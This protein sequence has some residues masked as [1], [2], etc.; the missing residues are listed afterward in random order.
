[1]TAPQ[2]PLSAVVHVHYGA[3]LRQEERVHT[4][5]V[6]VFGS[7]GVV[8]RHNRT[9]FDIPSIVIG[10]KGSVGA[11]HYAPNGG[12]VIDTAFYV[13]RLDPRSC[14]LRYLFHALSAAHLSR[15]AITTSIPGLSR[16]DIYRTRIPLPSLPEQQRIAD[17]LDKADAIRR[18]RKAAIALADDLLRSTFLD[19]FGDPVSNPK[20]WS[21]SSLES[22]ASVA[23]GVAKGKR[24]D[25]QLLVT[26]PYMRVA[27][28]Q[29]GYIALTDVKQ[30]E[31]TRR[32]AET[33]RLNPGDVLLTEG[34][35]PDKLG[36]GA[37]WRGEIDECIHQNHVFRVRSD[38]ALSPEFLS[39]QLG[40]ERGKRY[41]LRAAKQ[42]TGIASINM[43]QLRAF[44]L[45]LPPVSMQRR[46]D[47]AAAGVRLIIASLHR[48][49]CMADEL[50]RSMSREFFGVLPA[51]GLSC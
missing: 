4:G 34:G 51:G 27:N 49:W 22:C 7:S 31:V 3:A 35:D 30:M 38:G 23:S 37:V 18:K 48:R 21:V 29:D 36:R 24:N 16:D 19:M 28:V 11:V 41:F 8:G 13:E 20:G 46:F 47:E 42:T 12:W 32:D 40:S 2:V 39:S 50:F 17:M 1:M 9:L 10:R 14:D 6:D 45:L 43:S 5:G 33:Y 15:H 44:P 26:R 25:G